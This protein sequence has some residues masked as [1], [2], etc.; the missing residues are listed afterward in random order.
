MLTKIALLAQPCPEL[1][2]LH[3]QLKNPVRYAVRDFLSLEE[4]NTSLGG[5]VFD[6]LLIRIPV[7]SAQHVMVL[8]RARKRFPEAGL[9]TAASEIDFSAR[10]QARSIE[11]H[12]LIHEPSEIKD[13][14]RVIDKLK[15]GEASSLRMHPRVPREGEAELVEVETG[16]RL[17]ARFLDFAQ[18][19]ARVLVRVQEPLAKR[20]R[21]QLHYR[22]SSDINKIHRIESQ[23]VW[24]DMTGGM[25]ESIVKGPQQMVGLR[26]IAAL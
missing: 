14:S 8:D 3:E 16:R 18:M 12:K 21:V 10:F 22:S 6:I 24:Q 20:A 1:R 9:V 2:G 26:F 5:Y 17:K 11:R 23:V 25:F 4:V 19:G 7:F 15:K 13:L